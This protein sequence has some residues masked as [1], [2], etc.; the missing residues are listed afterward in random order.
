MPRRKIHAEIY[1]HGIYAP[2]DRNSAALPRLIGITTQIPI[3][4][5]IEFGYV[6]QILGAKGETLHFRINHPPFFN[7]EG[8]IA[9]PFEGTQ[10]VYSNDF[11]FFLGDTVWPPFHDK[12]GEWVLTTMLKGKII[13]QKKLKLTVDQVASMNEDIEKEK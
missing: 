1:S 13:A 3:R 8:N 6:L 9:P 7:E 5:D 11:K 12:A 2:W 4:Q 10:Y